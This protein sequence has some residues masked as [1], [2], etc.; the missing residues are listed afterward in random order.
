MDLG[1]REI[2]KGAADAIEKYVAG[3]GGVLSPEL[4]PLVDRIGGKKGILIASIGAAL[5]N[6]ALGVLTY[7]AVT[8]R[9][10]VRLVGL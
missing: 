6:I 4:R 3:N 5:A 1:G 7:L 10:R 9:L 2:R 8:S